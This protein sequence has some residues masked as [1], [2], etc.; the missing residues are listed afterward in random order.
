MKSTLKNNTSIISVSMFVENACFCCNKNITKNYICNYAQQ[1]PAI[2][3]FSSGE[4]TWVEIERV[5]S[6]Q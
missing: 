1:I 6:N 4:T 3:G 2:A 5:S